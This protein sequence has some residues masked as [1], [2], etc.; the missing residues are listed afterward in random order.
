MDPAPVKYYESRSKLERDVQSWVRQHGYAIS[1][2]SSKR[3]NVYLKC[4][5]GDAHTDRLPSQAIVRRSTSRVVNCSFLLR[6]REH[7]KGEE[8]GNW[9]LIILMPHHENHEAC[10]DPSSLSMLRRPSE[11][12]QERIR[13]L[14]AGGIAPGA[15]WSL[16]NNEDP[17]LL[18]R[19][20]DI[21]NFLSID[22]S[23]TLAGRSPLQALQEDL[24]AQQWPHVWRF[25]DYANDG[26]Q[27][28]ALVFV[29]PDSA[30]LAQRYC[31]IM[32]I[33]ANYKTN[34]FNLPLLHIVGMKATISSYTAGLIFLSKEDEQALKWALHAFS[35]LIPLYN[36]LVLLLPIMNYL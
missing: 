23:R 4:S 9:E 34:K 3:G 11:H 28:D 36:I 25:Q 1:V 12:Q 19:S 20:Q 32:V 29:Y 16:L 22:K 27:V 7:T 2:K 10:Q 18:L 33:D 8:C 21:Y 35:S 15:I 30:T 24:I 6:G 14:N 17:D 31:E 26:L 5:K 13:C